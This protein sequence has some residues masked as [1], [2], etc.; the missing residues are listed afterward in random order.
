MFA[1]EIIANSTWLWTVKSWYSLVEIRL[2][3]L[4]VSAVP[5]G[6]DGENEGFSGEHSKLAYHLPRVGHK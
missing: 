6:F 2:W 4:E 5:D 1:L 3:D